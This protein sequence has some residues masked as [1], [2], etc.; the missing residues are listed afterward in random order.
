[1]KKILTVGVAAL[2]AASLWAVPARKGLFPMTQADG[3]TVMV[4]RVGDEH[5][6][7]T[8]DADGNILMAE[9]GSMR[10]ADVTKGGV[11]TPVLEPVKFSSEKLQPLRDKNLDARRIPQKR[12][13]NYGKFPGATFPGT[14]KQKAIVILVEY[15]DVKF[16]LG[17]DAHAYFT[18]LLNEEGFSSFSSTVT[19]KKY[20]GTG[21]ARDYFLDS[22][23]GQFDCDFDLYGPV[24]LQSD[25]KAYGGNDAS[26]SDKAPWNM[27]IEACQLLDDTVDFSQYDRDGDGKID[28]VFIFYA[29]MGEAT[30]GPAESV[31]P[32]AY[33]VSYISSK[34]YLFDGVQL[35][36]YGCTN[37]WVYTYNAFGNKSGEKPDGVGTFVHEFSHVIGLPDL[38]N[39]A[40]GE[41]SN[42]QSVTSTPDY[43]SVLDYGPYNNNGCTPP[44]YS[45]FERN[46]MGWMTPEELPATTE[47]LTLK[48]MTQSNFAYGITNAADETEFYLIEARKKEGWDKYLPG[49]GML[50]W[51]ID[52]NDTDWVYNTVNNKPSH[53][54]VLL[55]AADGTLPKSARNG[56]DAFPGTKK[57]TT[58]T[59][60]W[61]VQGSTGITLNDIT[62]N[63]DKSVSF[64][65]DKYVA[66]EGTLSVADVQKSPMTE[67]EA[68]VRGYIMGYVASGTWKTNYV[69]FTADG[70][71]NSNVVLADT[72]DA[73]D[74]SQ[75]IP[76]QLKSGSDARSTL[77]LKDH[78]EMLGKQVEITGVLKTYCGT[79]AIYGGYTCK[80]L[81]DSSIGEI[82]SANGP[83]EYFDMLGRPVQH[84]EHG[85]FILKQGGKARTVKK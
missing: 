72:P 41:T 37:E 71:V 23:C 67:A 4:Q 13:A 28:N 40:G 70:A 33:N 19:G 44:A 21:S 34:K 84:P 39:T 77:N 69:K 2:T 73:T 22:S 58:Y 82:E 85:I 26:G 5:G 10:F 32:H 3:S 63:A 16:T 27:A 15:Q 1:M 31:W 12:V 55:V 43:W 64:T 38:Y 76:V 81:D 52:Y 54:G 48:P 80:V 42:G 25:R 62:Q 7:L 6:H 18:N 65:V 47:T 79:S 61:W 11:L 50:I 9:N 30:G 60:S 46:A 57:V 45:A 56:A 59:P 75:C 35:D 24:T 53:L 66:P 17:D 51:H 74:L 78:P 8:L 29:G 14:G 83:A 68:T 49:E 20:T 36:S